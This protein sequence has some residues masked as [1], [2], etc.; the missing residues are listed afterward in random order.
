MLFGSLYRT[1]VLK[2]GKPGFF[3]KNPK[4]F[5]KNVAI[6]KKWVY[7]VIKWS[8]MVVMWS[9]REEVRRK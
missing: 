8:E 7:T 9:K 5:K 2:L 1:S 4:N 3:E 6:L